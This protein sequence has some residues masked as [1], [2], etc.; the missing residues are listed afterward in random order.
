M[1]V[2]DFLDRLFACACAGCGG[3]G[4]AF[5]ARCVPAEAAAGR[6][7]LHGLTVHALGNYEGGLRRA[8]LALKRGRR[9]VGRALGAALAARFAH[10]LRP[11]DVLVPVPTTRARRLERG[12]NQSALLAEAVARHATLG[13]LDALGRVEGAPQ[14]GRDRDERLGAAGRFRAGR[15]EIVG[16]TSVVIVDDVVTTGA[17]LRD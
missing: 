17:T 7:M 11:H 5:C 8:V 4:G 6:L 1:D 3:A 2:S 12:F 10:E 16:E 15:P 13:V 14:Q 9:D